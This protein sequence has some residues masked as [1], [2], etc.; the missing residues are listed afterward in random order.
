[1]P[2]KKTKPSK[3]FGQIRV[4]QK[5]NKYEF[6]VELWMMRDGKIENPWM[7]ENLEKYY[8][9]FAGRPILIAYVMEKI[10]D[11]HNSRIKVDPA[12]GER[13]YS[14]TDGTAERIVGTLSDDKNDFSL[15]ERDGHTWVVAK[16][17]LFSFYAK[18][19]VDKIVRT[20]RMSVSVETLTHESHMEDDI[21]VITEW[22]GLAVTILGEG[23]APAVPGANIARLS[24]MQDEFKTLK[25][26]AASLQKSPENNAPNDGVKTRKG[27][28]KLNTYSKRQLA[29]LSARFEGYKV[30]AAG[31]QDG[32]VYVGLLSKD[33]A[34]KSYVMENAAETVVPEKF[35]SLSANTAI[36]FGEDMELRMDAME[37]TD[38]VSGEMQTR[39]NAAEE[40]VK[41]LSK[42]LE[43]SNKKVSDMEAFES[44]RRLNAAKD[45]AKKTL[46]KFNQNRA[47]KV[48]DS[49]IDAILKD[50]ESGLYTNCMK[51]GKWTGEA[52]VS[53]SV[54]AV[55]GEEVA[56]LDAAAAQKKRTMFAWEKFQQ[57]SHQDG[58]TIGDMLSAWGIDA[59]KE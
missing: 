46:A 37:F 3:S 19:L 57:N 24:A 48:A 56:K 28:K 43:D 55:C 5:L 12:T 16:G 25:L 59:A 22:E 10:G 4:L 8:Q 41:N 29:E 44:A 13:Y 2:L 45:A 32:K 33:G 50:V 36:A 18:E 15:A 54:Y 51:D 38:T 11:G 23:V 39:L 6:G 53:K 21:E 52:E 7:Y 47:E 35:V 26:R 34:L 58:G 1:M 27:V 49:A 17:K 30:L 40:S 31:E 9:T 42:Q 20:G 14:Y